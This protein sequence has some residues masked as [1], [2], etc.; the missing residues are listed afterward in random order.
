MLLGYNKVVP[1][2]DAKVV[3]T[4]GDDVLI[5]TMAVD[6]GRS[7]V[8]TSDIGPHW[9]PQEFLD[10]PGFDALVGG[11]LRWLLGES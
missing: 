1:K 7:L 11:M 2:P 8:W 3:A 9:C 5:A 10:W 4:I 6:K